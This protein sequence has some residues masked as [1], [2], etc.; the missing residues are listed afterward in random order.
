MPDKLTVKDLGK[1]L[2]G[3]YEFELI[4]LITV[5]RPGSLTNREA[6]VIKV[7]SGIRAGEIVDGIVYSDNDLL[8][9]LATVI[10]NRAGKTVNEEKLWDAKIGCLDWDIEMLKVKDDKPGEAEADPPVT[11]AEPGDSPSGG[12][13][14]AVTSGQN[15]SDPSPTGRHVSE[16]SAGYVPLISVS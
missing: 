4:D 16:T 9:A 10:L 11:P 13:S 15:Q 12:P 1:P 5:G 6:H 7:M 14:F 8:V 2:D 3:E